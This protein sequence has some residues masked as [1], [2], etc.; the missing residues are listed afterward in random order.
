MSSTKGV[1]IHNT[2][3]DTAR[4]DA[5]EIAITE[6]NGVTRLAERLGVKPAVVGNWKLRG[7]VPP[8]RCIDVERAVHAKVTR[9][10]LRPDVFGEPTQSKVA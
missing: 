1:D 6:C 3:R 5:L 8:E 10:Q 9:Y 4:M 2:Q 7:Q